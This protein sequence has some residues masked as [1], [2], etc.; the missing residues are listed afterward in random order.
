MVQTL[1]ENFYWRFDANDIDKWREDWSS[2]FKH[3]P[4]HVIRTADLLAD[5]SP[6]ELA[7]NIRDAAQT[8]I[9]QEIKTGRLRK[10]HKAFQAASS[11]I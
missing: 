2:A 8:I 9:M 3:K 11:M 4:G 5:C 1:K 10:L 7:R 6:A